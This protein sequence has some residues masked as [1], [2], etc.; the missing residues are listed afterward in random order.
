MFALR[1]KAAVLAGA[2]AIALSL[3]SPGKSAHA[4]P[5]KPIIGS[6]CLLASTSKLPHGW[7]LAQGQVLQIS[8]YE[9]L[10]FVLKTIY[11]AKRPR[12]S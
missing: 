7:L 6:L 9:N 5:V 1:P 2:A 11:G 10:Y 12:R 3:F 8:A 4:C